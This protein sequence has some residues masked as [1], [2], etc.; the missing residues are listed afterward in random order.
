MD[1]DAE[2]LKAARAE[3]CEARRQWHHMQ[4]EIE[5]LHAVVRVRNETGNPTEKRS[6]VFD[7]NYPTV[8]FCG[9]HHRAENHHRNTQLWGPPDPHRALAH[10]H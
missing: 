3:L 4:I 8:S 2:A 5:S 1:K 7:V 10:T 6:L 9:S